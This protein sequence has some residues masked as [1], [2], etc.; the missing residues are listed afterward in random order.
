MYVQQVTPNEEVAFIR[1]VE[2]NMSTY[3]KRILKLK[4]IHRYNNRQSWIFQV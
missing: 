4:M 2:V 1:S 3:S